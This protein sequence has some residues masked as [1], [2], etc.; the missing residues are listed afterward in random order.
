M[1]DNSAVHGPWPNGLVFALKPLQSPFFWTLKVTCRTDALA[2][3]KPT[4][5]APSRARLR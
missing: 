2:T 5:V 3:T 1:R 4:I